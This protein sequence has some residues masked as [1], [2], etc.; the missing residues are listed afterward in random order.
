VPNE[1]CREH[2]ALRAEGHAYAD[3]S[4]SLRY[5]IGNHAIKTDA[6]QKQRHTARDS[7]HDECKRGSRHGFLIE[8]LQRV[9]I[10]ERKIGIDGPDGF[11]H[12]FHEIF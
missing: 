6:P 7:D 1:H 10:G 3:L 9:D 8:I 12:I 11:A 2:L 4:R 5:G